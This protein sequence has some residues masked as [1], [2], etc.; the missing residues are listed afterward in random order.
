MCLHSG[1]QIVKV[2]VELRVIGQPDEPPQTSSRSSRKRPRLSSS[3][4]AAPLRKQHAP[5][6]PIRRIIRQVYTPGTPAVFVVI[7]FYDNQE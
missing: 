3:S 7:Y 1:F 6:T 5:D 4:P 2:V